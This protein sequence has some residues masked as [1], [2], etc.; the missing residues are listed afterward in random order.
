MNCSHCQKELPEN[1]SGDYCPFCGES[2]AAKAG[3]AAPPQNVPG[4][5]F[6]WWLFF[7]VLAAPAILDFV[8]I[9]FFSSSNFA[10]NLMA[11]ATF[12]GS[13]VAGLV[14]AVLLVR[15]Q[16][17][18]DGLESSGIPR[19]ILFF[20]L[21]SVVSFALCFVGCATAAVISPK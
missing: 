20:A 12:A 5:R 21:F 14:G 3:G 6:S 1:Y 9:S 13:P 11:L 17:E 15:W 18:R 10:L 19:G 2:A 16:S 4:R 8:L 7:L